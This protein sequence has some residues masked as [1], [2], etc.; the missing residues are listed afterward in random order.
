[1]DQ[2]MYYYPYRN[3]NIIKSKLLFLCR[4]SNWKF[5]TYYVEEIQN[6][7]RHTHATWWFEV[8]HVH[9]YILLGMYV[10]S[11]DAR[12]S[13]GRKKVPDP[14]VKSELHLFCWAAVYTSFINLASFFLYFPNQDIWIYFLLISNLKTTSFC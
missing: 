10:Q 14:C 5:C 9:I 11:N 12:T 1:M 13:I 8:L 7:S 4:S 6:Y 2:I 3:L